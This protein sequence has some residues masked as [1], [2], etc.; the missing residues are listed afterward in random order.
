MAPRPERYG[1]QGWSPARLV[2][3]GAPALSLTLSP[4]RGNSILIV[5]PSLG[6]HSAGR[7]SALH[8]IAQ[9]ARPT[10][11]GAYLCKKKYSA[12]K[13]ISKRFNAI[14]LSCYIFPA[15]GVRR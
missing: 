12:F 3:E 1:V 9:A 4:G 2:E 11:F 13:L 8:P 6:S 15:S 7:C 14:S 10:A 5:H